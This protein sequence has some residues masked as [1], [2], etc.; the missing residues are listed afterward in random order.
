MRRDLRAE[1]NPVVYGVITSVIGRATVR[2]L[3]CTTG[4]SRVCNSRTEIR[5]FIIISPFPRLYAVS[6]S[7][8]IFLTTSFLYALPFGSK[9]K[10]KNQQAEIERDTRHTSKNMY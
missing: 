7:N 3:F 2:S 8:L 10:T 6:S 9:F 1:V 4:Q 5:V